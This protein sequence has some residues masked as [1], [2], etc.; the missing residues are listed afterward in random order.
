MYARTFRSGIEVL[1][2]PLQFGGERPGEGGR[3]RAQCDAR[4][5][6]PMYAH[7]FRSG[8]EVLLSPPA[9]GGGGAG[10]GGAPAGAVRCLSCEMNSPLSARNER[11]GA[12]G[13]APR[14]Q[15]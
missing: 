7:T 14:A 9:V 5:S 11:G 13:G 2:S 4:R 3:Q 8:I 12:G 15:C 1:L 10:G 6:A